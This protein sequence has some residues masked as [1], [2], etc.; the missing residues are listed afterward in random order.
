[1]SVSCP[2][3]SVVV[4][5]FNEDPEILRG[6]LESIRNQTFTNFECIVI[7]DSTRPDLAAACREVCGEDDRFI[8]IHPSQRLGLSGSLNLGISQACGEFVAR[9]DSD[10]VCV[11]ERLAL[12]VQFLRA[13]PQISVVGGAMSIVNA[14]GRPIA[15]R[16]YPRTSKEIAKALQF[17]NAIAHPTVMFRKKV[18]ALHGAYNTYY[19]YCEDLDMW[20]RW[21]NAGVLFENLPHTLVH[22]RQNSTSRDQANWR[23]NLQARV[24]N[25]SSQHVIR[26]ILGVF[27]IALWMVVPKK[28]RE[29]LY[30]AIL[31]GH[32]GQQLND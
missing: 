6:S 4:P 21:M 19:R 3:V 26:R 10:D 28:C 13:N 24:S 17:T 22:Y 23:Y 8:Y 18:V 16:S 31:L 9:F 29:I 1:M 32:R 27:C 20:L 14:E 12:Q 2:L 11:P 30:K 7:D 25:F 15:H 5:S